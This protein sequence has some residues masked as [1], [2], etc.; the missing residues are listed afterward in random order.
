M[1]LGQPELTNHI[2]ASIQISTCAKL[3]RMSAGNIL[4]TIALVL[5]FKE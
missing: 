5:F 4:N 1:V 3:F 2:Y